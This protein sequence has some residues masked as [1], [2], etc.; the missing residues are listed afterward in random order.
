MEYD[1]GYVITRISSRLNFVR[2]IHPPPQPI[3]PILECPFGRP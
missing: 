3:R 2:S 1:M